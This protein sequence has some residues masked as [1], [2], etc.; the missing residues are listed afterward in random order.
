VAK[1]SIGHGETRPADGGSTPIEPAGT[2]ASKLWSRCRSI[3]SA[4]I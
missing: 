3:R 4:G 1:G 2:L